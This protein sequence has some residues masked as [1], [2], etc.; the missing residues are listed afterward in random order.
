MTQWWLYI[1][2]SYGTIVSVIAFKSQEQ[3]LG[4]ALTILHEHKVGA[5]LSCASYHMQQITW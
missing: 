1:E 4:I 5:M 2:N 3:C